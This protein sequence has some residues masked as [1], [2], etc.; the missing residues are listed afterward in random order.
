MGGRKR[1]PYGDAG[2]RR[3][4]FNGNGNGGMV[5]GRPSPISSRHRT[6]HHRSEA[7]NGATAGIKQGR[8]CQGVS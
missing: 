2:V 5:P 4:E 7:V 6:G 1:R 3:R 8:L